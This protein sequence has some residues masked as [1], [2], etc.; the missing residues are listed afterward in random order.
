M[1]NPASSLPKLAIFDMD[2]ILFNTEELFMNKKAYYLKQF[3]YPARKEDYVRTLGACGNTLNQ[4]LFDIYGADYPANE[5]SDLTRESVRNHIN[6]FGLEIK[7]G[8]PE[9]LK[10]LTEHKILCMVASSTTTSTVEHYLHISELAKYFSEV[11]GGDMVTNSKP[12]PEI[13]LKAFNLHKRYIPSISLQ[14]AVVFEDSENGIL[15][16][17]AAGIPS[18]C[19][20]DLKIP[21][22]N[23]KSL[24]SAIFNS[25]HDVILYYD[26]MKGM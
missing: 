4:I 9:L 13:F 11:I 23:I 19:I 12:D 5:I 1:N 14:E 21:E 25:A 17:H 24:T 10:Y 18:I 6:K 22:D 2:G 26:T 8:I 7:D 16:A 20:P 3:G 15:A